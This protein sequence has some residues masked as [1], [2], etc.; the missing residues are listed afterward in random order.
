M[1]HGTAVDFFLGALG[2]GLLFLGPL[3][4]TVVNVVLS[5]KLRLVRQIWYSCFNLVVAGVF[6][7]LV[8]ATDQSRWPHAISFIVKIAAFG[9]FIQLAYLLVRMRMRRKAAVDA[10]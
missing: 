1:Y 8:I 5:C 3:A 6:T 4:V 9:V 7:Y 10:A 2:L